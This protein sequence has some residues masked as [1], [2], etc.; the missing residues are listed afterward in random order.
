MP[1]RLNSSPEKSTVL[2]TCYL[3]WDFFFIPSA[4]PGFVEN[5]LQGDALNQPTKKFLYN[6]NTHVRTSVKQPFAWRSPIHEL[7]IHTKKHNLYL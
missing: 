7:D 5:I 1:S 4:S 6:K 3:A 2:K